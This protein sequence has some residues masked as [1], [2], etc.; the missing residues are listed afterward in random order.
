MSPKKDDGAPGSVRA[1][2]FPIEERI[3]VFKSDLNKGVETDNNPSGE[4]VFSLFSS[5]KMKLDTVY[6][7]AP[8]WTNK[9][10][11]CPKR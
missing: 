1:D 4:V 5:R 6:I 11:P 7:V 3:Y 9:K 2:R 10:I 8:L